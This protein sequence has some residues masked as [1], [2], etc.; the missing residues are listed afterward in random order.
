MKEDTKIRYDGIILLVGLLFAPL[1][2]LWS[3]GAFLLTAFWLRSFQYVIV[4]SAVALGLAAALYGDIAY[5]LP[6]HS[7]HELFIKPFLIKG[8]DTT[9]ITT[10]AFSSV[11]A[12]KT[13]AGY[14][15]FNE[16]KDWYFSTMLMPKALF[17]HL[18][19]GII[20]G[21]LAGAANIFINK[22]A[23]DDMGKGNRSD[24]NSSLIVDIAHS[25][26][27]SSA[28]SV[29]G[30]TVLGT[31]TYGG[32][33]ILKD[34]DANRHTLILGS[35]GSG[36][37]VTMSNIIESSIDRNMPTIVIDGKGDREL[38]KQICK[39]AHEQGRTVR[40]LA[41]GDDQSNCVYDAF[42]SGNY[43]SKLNRLITLREWSEDYY[44]ELSEKHFNQVFQAM[45]Y[46]GVDF[47]LSTIRH[48]IQK[49][50][51]LKLIRESALKEGIRDKEKA[52][53]Q[54]FLETLT[55]EGVADKEVSSISTSISNFANS[56]Y[57][58]HFYDHSH[59]GSDVLRLRDV[60]ERNEVVYIGLP[61]LESS[62]AASG[63][64]KLLIN[65]IKATAVD[66][67]NKQKHNLP[68]LN[69]GEQET[70]SEQRPETAKKFYLFF[71]EFGVFAGNQAVNV[72]NQLRGFGACAV[73]STQTLADI[74]SSTD[75]GKDMVTQ[76]LGNCNNCIIHQGVPAEDVELI[77]GQIGTNTGVEF[78]LQTDE[79]GATGRGS[80]RNTRSMILHPDDIKK[81]KQK[82]AYLIVAKEPHF[83]KC[84][85]SKISQ[86]N[87]KK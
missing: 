19:V 76:I 61:N 23:L 31:K 73:L 80:A 13:G 5:K 11:K 59:E 46:L 75:K 18:L 70:P 38:G 29:E 12:F 3:M 43:T 7:A 78:T 36:K 53:L 50:N 55:Q 45:E 79:T 16:M 58:K 49:P 87:L 28:A 56:T 1:S 69:N 57:G 21:G 41:F 77:S 34:V 72:V 68:F 44:K 15:P 14:P 48:Y 4:V 6:L 25:G 39:Y 32:N 8:I 47:D 20:F 26:K 67:A 2:F 84:R 51:I 40:Y 74:S 17:I 62:E 30:G 37:T 66:I 33:A 63:L 24:Q 64:G 86:E 9:S 71:D 85:F 65:D 60:L 42:S 27:H 81:L 10:S 35:S 54:G 52:A 22:S 82:Q 83:I